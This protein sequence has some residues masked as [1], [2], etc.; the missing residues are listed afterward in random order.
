MI[1]K[2]EEPFDYQGQTVH[3][4][5]AGRP[6]HRARQGAQDHQPPAPQRH[7]DLVG[8]PQ[9]P[10]R[11]GHRR[12]RRRLAA[13][14][15]RAGQVPAGVGQAARRPARP[16]ATPSLKRLDIAAGG[17]VA[18]GDDLVGD[19]QK[20][21]LDFARPTRRPVRRRHGCPGQ[22]LLQRHLPRRTA[23]RRR[24]AT[25]QD[26]YLEGKKAEAAAAV[27]GEMLE[28]VAP[29]RSQELRQGAHR[30]VQGG[31]CHRAVGEPGRAA[32]RSKTIETLREIVDEA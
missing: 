31:G 20:A 29:R 21:I 8:E 14:L 26:L 7:P 13:D 18:I 30:C 2:R 16:S 17:M 22:E 1:W 28:L 9:G 10:Q 24:P 15:L 23:T 32:T 3:G 19:K 4:A 25:I 12:A 11:R 27:P 6:G 5:A